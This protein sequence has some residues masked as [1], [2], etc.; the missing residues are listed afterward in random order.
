M[1]MKRETLEAIYDP[2]WS[3]PMDFTTYMYNDK[4]GPRLGYVTIHDIT[5][6]WRI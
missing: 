4:D 1:E 3:A 5:S 6:G 2:N